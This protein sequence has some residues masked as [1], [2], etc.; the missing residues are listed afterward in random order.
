MAEFDRLPEVEALGRLEALYGG[1]ISPHRSLCD[2]ST[3]HRLAH[4]E[5]CTVYPS[6][7]TNAPLWP[8]LAAMLDARRFLEIGTGLGYTAALMAEAGGPGCQVDTIEALGEHAD[9]AEQEV[10]QR[11]LADRIRVLRGTAREVLPRLTVPY[12]VVF[13]DA[14]W[15]DYPALLPHLLRLARPGGMLVTSN[16]FPLFEPWAQHLSGK[17]AIEE[18]LRRLL[19]E[20]GVRTFIIPGLWKALS[21]RVAPPL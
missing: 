5:G 12:D 9:L 11:H 3:A 17:E 2:R 8:L 13:L 19:R 21:Y 1:P 18:Y 15:D 6:S 14:D 10:A 4:G 16:L 7:P 20:P